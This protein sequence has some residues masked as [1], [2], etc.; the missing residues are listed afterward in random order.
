MNFFYIHSIVSGRFDTSGSMIPLSV[1][2]IS[3]CDGFCA[4]Q[5][6]VHEELGILVVGY[7]MYIVFVLLY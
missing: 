6:D 5:Q 1:S 4:V 7:D 3:G 2:E